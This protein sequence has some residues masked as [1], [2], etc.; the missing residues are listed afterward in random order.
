MDELER[1][2]GTPA[3]ERAQPHSAKVAR[4]EELEWRAHV[5]AEDTRSG[6]S[7]GHQWDLVPLS[8]LPPGVFKALQKKGWFVLYQDPPYQFVVRL[9]KREAERAYYGPNGLPDVYVK[10]D[11]IRYRVIV[12]GSVGD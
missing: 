3:S 6:L 9:P 8:V 4:P 10:V 1:I 5:R 7:R 12:D 11:G 2:T